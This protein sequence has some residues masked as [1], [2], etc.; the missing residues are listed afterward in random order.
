MFDFHIISNNVNIA[1]SSVNK[2]TDNRPLQNKT[3]LKWEFFPSKNFL[4]LK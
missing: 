2:M 3:T 1:K 4:K